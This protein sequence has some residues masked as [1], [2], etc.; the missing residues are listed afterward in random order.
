[1]RLVELLITLVVVT[2]CGGSSS[3]VHGSEGLNSSKG[4]VEPVPT[5]NDFEGWGMLKGIPTNKLPAIC[6]H[7]SDPNGC[8]RA[9][10]ELNS[11]PGV[12]LEAGTVLELCKHD[13]TPACFESYGLPADRLSGFL[14]HVPAL[15]RASKCT[16]PV[17]KVL[18]CLGSLKD[19]NLITDEELSFQVGKALE[20]V[21]HDGS[22]YSIG[23]KTGSAPGLVVARQD[24]HHFSKVYAEVN[25]NQ[26]MGA[27]DAFISV[28]DLGSGP[29]LLWSKQAMKGPSFGQQS[30]TSILRGSERIRRVAVL[31]HGLPSGDHCT[32]LFQWLDQHRTELTRHDLVQMPSN[33][34]CSETLPQLVMVVGTVR[35]ASGPRTGRHNYVLEEL[36]TASDF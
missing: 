14:D 21:P 26:F 8:V 20:S 7:F 13:L 23:I 27:N 24:H 17:G 1:M 32:E 18:Q 5:G 16:G 25:G 6:T 31:G 22:Y 10:V 15:S 12:P 33:M 2:G 34:W 29:I 19:Q 3:T 30:R 4:N 11:S 36:S 35:E 9:G 28:G